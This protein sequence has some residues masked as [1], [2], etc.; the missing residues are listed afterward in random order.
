MHYVQFQEDR[1]KNAQTSLEATFDV[2][3]TC[4]SCAYLLPQ[5]TFLLSSWDSGFCLLFFSSALLSMLRGRSAQLPPHSS[6]AWSVIHT[7]LVSL[8][9]WILFL[10]KS[11]SVFLIAF[12]WKFDADYVVHYWYK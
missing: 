10:K 7:A 6:G 1:W 2:L 5:S 12:I 4:R 9:S 11:F 8:Y 3:L